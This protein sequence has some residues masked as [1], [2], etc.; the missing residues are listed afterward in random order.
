MY[1]P[2]N[3]VSDGRTQRAGD[4]DYSEGVAHLALVHRLGQEGPGE[5]IH[6]KMELM[7][8]YNRMWSNF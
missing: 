5:W 3:D 4:A 8:A 7:L 1:V 6:T 2:E